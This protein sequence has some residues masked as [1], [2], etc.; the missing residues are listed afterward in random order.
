MMDRR[1]RGLRWFVATVSLVVG[2]CG[3]SNPTP[4]AGPTPT[5]TTSTAAAAQ[6]SSPAPSLEVVP[7]TPGPTATPAPTPTPTPTPLFI[8]SAGWTSAHRVSATSGCNTVAAGIDPA[9]RYHIVAECN[10]SIRYFT[11]NGIG[12]W[13]SRV[14]IHPANRMEVGPQIGFQG[15]VVYIAYS[16][17]APDEGC[18]SDGADVGVYFRTRT[19]PNGA[20][21]AATRIGSVA[22][23]LQSF[24]VDGTTLHAT[25]ENNSRVYYETLNVSTFHRY[26][27]PG[28]VRTSLRIAS[29]G[30]ARIAYEGAAGIRYAV[31]Q[32]SGF[33]T[34]AISGSDSDDWA[35]VLVLDAGDKPHVLWTRSGKPGGCVTGD[36]PDHGTYYATN[37]SGTWV[38]QRI[39]RATGDA[40]LQV[41]A[42]TGRVHAVVSGDSGLVY[43][44]MAANGAWAH[45]KV[46][47]TR[48]GLS[49]A[50]R[51]DPATGT[52]L[53]V[54]IDAS[55][56]G[57]Q[58]IYTVTKS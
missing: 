27:I 34:S 39:T 45:T 4:P 57:N 49:L 13:T 52:L 22:D 42:T 26:P 9:S 14:F 33:S 55:T 19:L 5:P 2:A 37:T 58:R 3:S 23:R 21:S 56:A 46:A 6:T 43:Y 17:L 30:R 41:D 12:S 29:D 20:W 7:L 32:G 25:V 50:I 31:F 15:D 36:V 10:N 11:S 8:P 28:A 24:R 35:P 53:V 1:D 18:G 48:W 44:T 16:R 47:G 54:Y 51:L 38:T 40:S